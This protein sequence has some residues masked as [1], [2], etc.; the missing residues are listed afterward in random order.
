MQVDWKSKTKTRF[1]IDKAPAISTNGMVV[2]NNPLGS[3][4]G[5]EMLAAGG[6]AV[7]AAIA[8]LFALTVVEPM[9]VGIFG[10]GMSTIRLSDGSYHCIN[11]YSRAPGAALPEMFQPLSGTWPDY[12]EVAGRDNDIGVLSVGVPGSLKGWCEAL[13]KYGRFTL[14]DVLQ[15][16]I[17]H[18]M[19]GFH[20]TQYL[21]EIV[22]KLVTDIARF[23]ETARTFLPG[24]KP[25]QAGDR[26][27]QS[28]Y[29]ETLKLIA[30][31]GPDVLY[32][33]ELGA[34][35]ADYIQHEGG[36]VTRE[37]LGNYRTVHSE[38][39]RGS[40][41]GYDIIGPA[42]PSAGGVQIVEMLNI[43]EVF[44]IAEMG[45]GTTESIHLLAEILALGF[46]DRR[47]FTGDPEFV[48][49][50][51]EKL[52]SEQYAEQRRAL[53]DLN[54]ARNFHDNHPFE[55]NHTTHLTT[56][57]ADGNVVA[58]THT[59]HS[60]FGSK[61]TVPGTG[62]L[63]NNTMY[64]FDP[65]PGLAN[66]IAPGKRMTSSMSPVIVENRGRPAFAL[67]SV[68][69]TRIFPS[70][71]QAIVNVI[72]HGMTAQE[73]VEAPRVWTQGDVLEVE[74]GLSDQILNELRELGHTVETLNI[75][76]AGMSMIQF[77]GE[78]MIGASCWRAD[79]T[80]VAIGGGMA[81]KGIRFDV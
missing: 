27:I 48:T 25:I 53:I 11:N 79:G 26:V 60:A 73:A 52:V 21:H 20:A 80:P 14:A 70:V 10:A 29:A 37:D 58:A 51:V 44:D 69:G 75:I 62:M 65:H 78:N 19:R 47:T 71:F 63:L 68:G 36:L 61:V 8:S 34:I 54:I 12:Q 13:E 46:E 57:D 81:R 28:D 56:A 7:D 76:G 49:V 16:A 5:A 41:R 64:I 33:G 67:G 77:D 22:T 43:L 72:D 6:N 17:G 3:T 45:F 23:P 50:P 39:V 32:A 40:Y 30:Q 15:P 24:G 38:V 74:R 2:T 1:P 18:A 66:S 9:M 4:A 35:A 59:L 42:P 31:H 55:S